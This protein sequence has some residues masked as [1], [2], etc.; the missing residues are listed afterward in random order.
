[1]PP[2][3]DL[4][5]KR[6]PAM[7]PLYARAALRLSDHL[8]AGASIAPLHARVAAVQAGVQRLARY[9]QV[10]A[11]AASTTLPVTWPHVWA[12]PLH[13]AVMTHRQ[14]PLRL[15]GL[16][17]VRNEIVQYRAV[18][19]N[20]RLTMAVAVASQREAPSGLEFDLATTLRD[21]ADTVVWEETSTMLARRQRGKR[22]SRTAPRADER[23]AA[24]YALHTRWQVPANIG[25]RYAR[26]AGDWNPIHLSAFSARLFGFRQ[27]I[28]TGM[29][30]QARVAAELAPQLASNAYRL[31]LTF[32]K[33]VPLP[34]T[35]T[36]AYG[37]GAQGADFA[38]V[39]VGGQ[40]VHLQGQV[41]YL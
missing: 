8:E 26:V 19:A 9:R 12:L 25:R 18:Q 41:S 20:E 16:V 13:M 24:D 6:L 40:V 39:D 3:I 17:H 29:W 2:R 21:D 1:M 22:R 34:S 5:Y 36:L 31:Q 38:L 35:V 33:P 23:S 28:A 11:F 4:E 7:L 27:A 30:L 32:R 10:C 15:L 14:F 37:L